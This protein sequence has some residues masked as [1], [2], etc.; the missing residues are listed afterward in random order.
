LAELGGRTT[1]DTDHM[2]TETLIRNMYEHWRTVME[3]SE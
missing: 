1:E 3:E 2:V